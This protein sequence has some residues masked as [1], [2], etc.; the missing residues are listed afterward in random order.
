MVSLQWFQYL[1]V[2]LIMLYRDPVTGMGT[3]NYAAM[4]KLYMSLP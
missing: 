1:D 2:R 3:P 4:L